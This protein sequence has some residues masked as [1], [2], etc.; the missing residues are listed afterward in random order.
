MVG[1]SIGTRRRLHVQDVFCRQFSFFD[2]AGMNCEVA[3]FVGPLYSK[4]LH[5]GSPEQDIW[6]TRGVLGA[7][8]A[9]SVLS[10]VWNT[11]DKMHQY[12]DVK[13]DVFSY[14]EEIE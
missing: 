14:I 7:G 6:K 8:V 1:N 4:F 13:K 12:L 3:G 11:S 9:K 5:F 2:N 10:S